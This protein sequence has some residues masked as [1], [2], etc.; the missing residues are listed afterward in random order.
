MAVA[1][2]MLQA[3]ERGKMI[4]EDDFQRETNEG[5]EDLGNG[6]NT[7]SAARADGAKQAEIR[8]GALYI[9]TD[10]KAD[11]RASIRH[12]VEFKDGMIGMRVMLPGPEDTLILD[13]ADPKE[14]S[15]HAGHLFAVTFSSGKTALEDL[16]TGRAS[17]ALKGNSDKSALKGKKISF[18]KGVGTGEWHAVE[19]EVTGDLLTV[20]IDG[21]KVGSLASEGFAHET[22]RLLR[23]AV[24]AKAVIDDVK[25]YSRD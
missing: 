10:E 22:K 12:G 1:T 2:L 20:T 21:E 17:H 8:D 9:Q 23:I 7:N 15:V 24:P 13:F 14:K 5:K 3:A 16:K 4:F 6:W 11:H 18:E 25:V 19:V